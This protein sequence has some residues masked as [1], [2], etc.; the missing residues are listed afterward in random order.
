MK[1]LLKTITLI[2]LPPGFQPCRRD[3]Y[4]TLIDTDGPSEGI[5]S[6]ADPAGGLARRR[7]GR[8]RDFRAHHGPEEAPGRHPLRAGQPDVPRGGDFPGGRIARHQPRGRRARR[9]APTHGTGLSRGRR[10]RRREGFPAK[11][12]TLGLD[13]TPIGTHYPVG[14]RRGQCR[15]H[16]Q[17]PVRRW[18]AGGQR[19]QH[20]VRRQDNSQPT[21]SLPWARTRSAPLASSRPPRHSTHG[22]NYVEVDN[23]YIDC[24]WALGPGGSIYAPMKRDAYE[25]SEFDRRATC[26]GFRTKKNRARGPRP[27][28]TRSSPDQPGRRRRTRTGRSR[29]TTHASRVSWYDHDDQ[30]VWV[31]TPHG[32]RTSPRGSWKPGMCSRPTAST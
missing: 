3:G 11:L 25:I 8:G 16:D 27:K 12:V 18:C 10:H 5:E 22:F 14:A 28:R 26:C 15:G 1:S 21:V 2:F 7:R 29:T 20:S 4:S 17:P 13:G 19:R 30:T 24:S 6:L 23:Y 31:L 32:P 9:V